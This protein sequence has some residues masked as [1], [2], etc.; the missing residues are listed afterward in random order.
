[1]SHVLVW[2]LK[3]LSQASRIRFLTWFNILTKALR[4]ESISD[5]ELR[6]FFK[7]GEDADLLKKRVN[8]E[9]LIK[10][11][12]MLGFEPKKLKLSEDEFLF[13]IKYNFL[14]SLSKCIKLVLKHVTF[15]R[16]KK[17]IVFIKVKKKDLVD[18]LIK[19]DV[20]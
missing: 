3:F 11:Y 13:V 6:D 20:S 2:R 8:F 16:I 14:F 18:L 19:G 7:L 5:D 17:E 9:G 4:N 12:Y 1:M 10:N 15:K